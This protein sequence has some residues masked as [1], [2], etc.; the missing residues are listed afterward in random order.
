MLDALLDTEDKAT[1]LVDCARFW[2]F[3]AEL[4]R[5]RG[6]SEEIEV[7]AAAMV[8]E[9][10]NPSV[11]KGGGRADVLAFWRAHQGAVLFHLLRRIALPEDSGAILPEGFSTAPAAAHFHNMVSSGAKL[12]DPWQLAAGEEIGKAQMQSLARHLIVAAVKYREAKEN[13]SE[14]Q[15]R[16]DLLP[17]AGWPTSADREG[18]RFYR[19]WRDWKTKAAK[20][21]WIERAEEAARDGT[22]TLP[23]TAD[24]QQVAE[25]WQWARIGG[26]VAQKPTD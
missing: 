25:W 17:L 2:V 9:Q 18:A 4:A 12:I 24:E 11:M 13:I 8:A 5:E 10:H 3:V 19:T 6:I 7:A 14:A 22:S 1:G 21:G 15:A 23:F 20:A 26:N 16:R